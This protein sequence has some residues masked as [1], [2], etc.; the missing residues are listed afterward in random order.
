MVQ[1]LS[2]LGTTSYEIGQIPFITKWVSLSLDVYELPM[3]RLTFITL[4]KVLP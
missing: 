1:C 4:Y 2:Q 3:N